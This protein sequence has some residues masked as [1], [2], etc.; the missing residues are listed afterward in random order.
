M[1]RLALSCAAYHDGVSVRAVLASATGQGRHSSFAGSASCTEPARL[2]SATRRAAD[3]AT[4]SVPEL[5][6]SFLSGRLL[7]LPK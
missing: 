4:M 1:E 7:E 5:P 6:S 2:T 3:K